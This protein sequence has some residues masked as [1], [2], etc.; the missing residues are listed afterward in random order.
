MNWS[1]I[2]SAEALSQHLDDPA[3][4]IVDARFALGAANADVGEQA[5]KIGHLPNAVYVHLDRDLSDKQKPAEFGRHPLPDAKQ[6]CDV[7]MRCGISKQSQVV[8]YDANDG[9]MA[10]ARTW[11]LLRLLGH[12]KA[13][14]LDGGI[15][16]WQELGLPVNDLVPSVTRS[17]YHAEFDWAGIVDT[18]TI[19]N[20][21][22]TKQFAVVDARAA[23]RYRGEVEPIDKKAGHIPGAINR[24]YSLNVESGRFRE[25]EVL[26][27]EFLQLLGNKKASETILYCGSGVTAC[28]N[29]LAM[30]VAGLSGAKIYSPSWS[31][32]IASE[33]NKIEK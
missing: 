26:Q 29:L 16:R 2:V 7:L 22:A 4:V 15:T 6:F 30:E 28:H 13:A 25:A 18:K 27:K 14:V 17:S 32:W 10:A 19:S 33:E 31:G 9:A 23:E 21:I 8:V 12:Q 24:P 3:L 1:T 20:N 11:Y 5:W